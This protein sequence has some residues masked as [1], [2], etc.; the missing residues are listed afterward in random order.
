[1]DAVASI[2]YLLNR[3]DI[4]HNK[5]VLYGRSLGG[6]V[7]IAVSSHEKYMHVLFAM[8]LENTF[9][10]IPE[11]SRH[12]FSWLKRLPTWCYKNVVREN[13]FLFLIL[14]LFHNDINL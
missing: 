14:Y 13:L 1:M 5:I 9:T 12:L 11:I 6:A 4:D 7:A 10:S 3:S 8:I 2:E